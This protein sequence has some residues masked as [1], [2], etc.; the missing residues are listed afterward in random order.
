MDG[1]V[2]ITIKELSIL[3]QNRQYKKNGSAIYDGLS[4]GILNVL[5]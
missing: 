5:H 2:K 4:K 1:L 3:L